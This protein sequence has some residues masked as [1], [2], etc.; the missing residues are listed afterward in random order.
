M[1][2]TRYFEYIGDGYAKVEWFEYRIEGEPGTLIWN[3][4]KARALVASGH[5]TFDCVPI[6]REVMQD[7]ANQ[8]EWD[9][10]HVAKADPALPGIASPLIVPN[11]LH[12]MVG[13]RVII[14]QIIDG[15][16]RCVRALQ[17]GLPFSAHLLTDEA[18]RACYQGPTGYIP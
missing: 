13:D 8:N 7:I 15:I 18:A 11:N 10:S 5:G 2:D 16:H 6:S 4:T 1:S 17:L 3:V 12:G 14:Y 9:P